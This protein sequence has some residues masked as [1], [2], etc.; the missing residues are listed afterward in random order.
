MSSVVPSLL[1]YFI[2]LRQGLSLSL[3]FAEGLFGL[4]RSYYYYLEFTV[5]C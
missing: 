5:W 4:V 3:L 2:F 1:L